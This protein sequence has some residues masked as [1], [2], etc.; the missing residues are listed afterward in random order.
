VVMAHVGGRYADIT[1][2]H[3]ASL[4]SAVEVHSAWGTFE[5]IIW[6]A[7]DKGYRVG[8][9]ANSDGHK[10]RPGADYPG[11]SFFGARGSLTCHLAP[12]LDRGAIFEC[13]RRRR[14]YAT[15]GNRMILDVAVHI[16]EGAE[17]F[18][19]DPVLGTANSQRANTLVMGDIAQAGP[20]VSD[21][22]LA[23]SAI[24]SAPIERLDVFSGKTLL[25]TLRPYSDKHLGSRVRL[26]FEGA[27]YRGRSRATTWDGSLQIDG[28]AILRADMFNNWNLDRGIREQDAQH[29]A[30]KA[31][32]TGNYCGIDLWLRDGMTGELSIAT[33]H[34]SPK[35]NI[36]DIG[37][38]DLVIDAGGL[39]RR[40]R[41][42]RLPDAMEGAKIGHSMKVAVNPEGDTP[43]FARVTQEDGHRAWSSPI[44]LIR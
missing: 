8:I 1:F 31:V 42:Y 16:A 21:V 33:R 7:F 6:D 15:T 27:E 23:I 37:L 41:L 13:M 18:D 36:A 40:L 12:S 14:H 39:E 10:G 25:K 5:W 20:E 44:Y 4:E 38:E 17:V 26:I 22:E 29:V 43:L 2:A 34:A 28:N 11:A 19:R 35:I 32:T 9:V 30:W 3:D 24:G